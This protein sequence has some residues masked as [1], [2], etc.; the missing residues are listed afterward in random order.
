MVSLHSI[1]RYLYRSLILRC[2]VSKEP[3]DARAN[4]RPALSRPLIYTDFA[5]LQAGPRIFSF[6]F[7]AKWRDRCL[8]YHG[9]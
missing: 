3:A 6:R 2:P 1:F 9:F 8:L 7:S 5:A 4:A